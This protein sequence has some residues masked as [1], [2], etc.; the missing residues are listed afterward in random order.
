MTAADIAVIVRATSPVIKEALALRD[1]RIAALEARLGAVEQKPA[2]KW[3]GTWAEGR[4]YTEGALTTKAGSLWLC[5][6][7]TSLMPGQTPHWRLIVKSG[8]VA[9]R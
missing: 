7:T 2:L 5:T 4:T 9:E 1:S 3:A 8:Q 6:A